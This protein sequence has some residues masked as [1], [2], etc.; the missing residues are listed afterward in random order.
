MRN[1][2][3]KQAISC[4]ALLAGLTAVAGAGA[5]CSGPI[6]VQAVARGVQTV[7]PFFDEALQLGVDALV[8]DTLALRGGTK[9]GN[10]P[11]LY[12]GTGKKTSCVKDR[13]VG[14]LRDPDN[15]R[16]AEEWADV[17]G[18]D[19]IDE[20]PGF[21]KK[22]T[23]V[24]LRNDT[25]VK[26]HDYRKGKAVPY[27]ALLE[28][29]IA[30]L[31]DGYGKPV[32]KCTCGNPLGTS[33]HDI[34][35]L[36]G[37]FEGRR[38]PWKGYDRT[39]VVKIE[40]AAD[41]AVTTYKLVDVESGEAGLAR[42]AGTDGAQDELLP[43]DPDSDQP[44]E[45]SPSVAGPEVSVSGAEPPVSP[46]ATATVTVGPAGTDPTEPGASVTSIPADHPGEPE[47]DVGG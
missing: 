38:K 12:G 16:K 28:A 23:P 26:N 31:I 40:A 4:V 21:V 45:V 25:L 6:A 44:G 19:D 42:I 47:G 13:L 27:E 3:F 39:K 43:A 7:A 35:S 41:E 15:R 46:D 32:V 10:Q 24:V 17:Q 9:K 5:A 29:G 33:D 37:Q 34:G 22:L 11:G 30:V 1:R 2:A 20:I 36:D 8:G 14:F 18:L